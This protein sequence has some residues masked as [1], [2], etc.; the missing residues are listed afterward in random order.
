MLEDVEIETDE[1][2]EWQINKFKHHE[3][4]MIH[5]LNVQLKQHEALAVGLACSHFVQHNSMN[6]KEI[7][8]TFTT[9]KPVVKWFKIASVRSIFNLSSGLRYFLLLDKNYG[10]FKMV[11]SQ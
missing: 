8:T 2:M 10:K 1:W 3:D 7:S 9:D 4:Q 5:N 6:T 11:E